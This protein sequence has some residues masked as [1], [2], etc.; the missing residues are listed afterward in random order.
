MVCGCLTGSGPRDSTHGLL[1]VVEQPWV[2]SHTWHHLPEE[3]GCAQAARAK[4]A[5][6]RQAAAKARDQQAAASARAEQRKASSLQPAVLEAPTPTSKPRVRLQ[7]IAIGKPA[8][9]EPSQVRARRAF[10]LQLASG[11]MAAL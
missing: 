3:M 10:Q 11:C 4:R 2:Q 7:P 8:L 1:P 9:A 6:A 5:A